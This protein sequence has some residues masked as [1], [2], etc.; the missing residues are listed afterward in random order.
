LRW[1]VGPVEDEVG[2]GEDGADGFTLHAD[3]FAVN[4]P[5][6]LEAFLMGQTQVLFDDCFNITW[7][8]GVEIED[9]GDLDLDRVWERIVRIY[10]VHGSIGIIT[11]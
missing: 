7:T 3:S 1:G 2:A 9:V 6:H 5:H 11:S 8:N 10:A 4:D